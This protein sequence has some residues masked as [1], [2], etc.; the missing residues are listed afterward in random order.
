MSATFTRFRTPFGLFTACNRARRRVIDNWPWRMV[1]SGATPATTRSPSR[2]RSGGR[3]GPSGWNPRRVQPNPLGAPGGLYPSM[4]SCAQWAR[5]RSRGVDVSAARHPPDKLPRADLLCP[6]AHRET[7]PGGAQVVVRK[8]PA[9]E[10]PPPQAYLRGERVQLVYGSVA[11]HVA[12]PPRPVALDVV[13]ED[14]PSQHPG[15]WRGERLLKEQ[16][17]RYAPRRAYHGPVEYRL[18]EG[19]PILTC[20]GVVNPAQRQDQRDQK[21][22]QREG[23]CHAVTEPGGEGFSRG[24]GWHPLRGLSRHQDAERY[25]HPQHR[26]PGRVLRR[27]M[28]PFSSRPSGGLCVWNAPISLGGVGCLVD[29]LATTRAGPVLRLQFFSAAAA[30]PIRH[31]DALPQ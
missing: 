24:G 11:D 13:D 10:P 5:L 19:D 26:S 14:H 7:T 16:H 2:R 25:Q 31:R 4:K 9:L 22:R 30:V 18:A 15:G 1:R 29:R 28:P 12:P 3:G 6:L 20:D 21:E 23:K 8:P 27:P 17:Y